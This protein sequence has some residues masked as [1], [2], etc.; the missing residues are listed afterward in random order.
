MPDFVN[1]EHVSEI[2]NLPISFL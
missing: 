2:P 1:V